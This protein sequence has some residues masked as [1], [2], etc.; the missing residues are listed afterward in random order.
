MTTTPDSELQSPTWFGTDKPALEEVRK[1]QLF[2][3]WLPCCEYKV[4]NENVPVRLT[5][6]YVTLFSIHSI[7]SP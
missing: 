5:E 3:F 2:V 7:L 1:I 4:G 6:L